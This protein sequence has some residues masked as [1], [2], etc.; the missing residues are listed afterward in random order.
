MASSGTG[1]IGP[2][3]RSDPG[4]RIVPVNQGGLS[5][6]E[7]LF[8][9]AIKDSYLASLTRDQLVDLAKA[10]LVLDATARVFGRD[11][12]TLPPNSGLRTVAALIGVRRMRP[13]TLRKCLE[14]INAPAGAYDTFLRL[15]P[16]AI[17][18]ERA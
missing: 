7:G 15:C 9:A 3:G 17:A 2:Q 1:T 10:A 12:D 8:D 6:G 13:M 4:D 14:S 16:G 11:I 18:P 5:I